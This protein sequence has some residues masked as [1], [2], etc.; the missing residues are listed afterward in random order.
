M[1][2]DFFEHLFLPVYLMSDTLI[3]LLPD[4]IAPVGTKNKGHKERDLNKSVW[5]LCGWV[6]DSIP[7]I[8]GKR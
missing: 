4:A 1:R 7:N 5:S 6:E 8:Y 3:K 2:S